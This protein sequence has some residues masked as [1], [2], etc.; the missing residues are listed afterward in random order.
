MIKTT[1]LFNDFFSW[2]P[3][4]P[5]AAWTEKI[6]QTVHDTLEKNVHG[7]MKTWCKALEILPEIVVKAVHLNN[8]ALTLAAKQPLSQQQQQALKTGLK[9]LCPWRKGPFDFFGE[10]IDTEW[11]SDWKWQRIF[12]YLQPLKNRLILDVGCGS[13]YHLWRMLGQHAR[14]V[15]GIDPSV[16]FMLQLQA[17]KRYAGYHL[18]IDILPLRMED[19][20]QK[21]AA[22]DTVF[23]MGVLYHRKSPLDHLSAL[24]HA[25]RPGGELVLETLVVHGNE[26][27]VLIPENRYAQMNNVWFLPSTDHLLLWLKRLNFT[28]SRVVNL[29]YTSTEEQ[30][31]TQWMQRQSLKN[32]LDPQDKTKTIEGYPAP[33]RVTI[34]ANRPF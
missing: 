20:P 11:R 19:F 26:K 24:Y 21:T 5:L 25:L 33:L 4:S 32:F 16:L 15:T 27:T 22:F 29:N 8:H 17:F 23:S 9:G 14:R 1:T 7:E 18:P 12:P 34:L 3:N 10:Y 6:Q 31:S 2:L 30:R 28:N 13:G